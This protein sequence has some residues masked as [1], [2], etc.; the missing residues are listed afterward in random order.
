M[1]ISLRAH[2]ED[3]GQ[4]ATMSIHARTRALRAAG[5]DVFQ[6]GFGQS[7]FPVPQPVVEALRRHAAV[8]DYLPVEGLPELRAAV[9]DYHRRVDSLDIRADDVLVGPGSKELM[10][11][12]QLAFVGELLVPAP[13]WVSYVPQ[14]RIAGRSVRMLA[15]S[16]ADGHRLSPAQLDAA[17]RDDPSRPRILVLNYPS[18]PTG[19]SYREH[20]LAEL[21]AV[22]R[23]HGLV[24]LSDEIYA[25]LDHTGSHVSIARW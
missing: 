11:L 14:A 5:R 6:F 24:V 9:A 21:A 19:R 25:E 17:C 3:R 18:N 8:K 15:T 7:P 23:R 16:A 1:S 12:L 20:E 10:F 13:A 4:S 2:P 22:A